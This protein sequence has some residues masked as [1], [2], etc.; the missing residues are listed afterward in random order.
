[1]NQIVCLENITLE[2]FK[3]VPTLCSEIRALIQFK[4]LFKINNKNIEHF[5]GLQKCFSQEL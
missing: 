3:K 5:L 2:L 4:H 1:M